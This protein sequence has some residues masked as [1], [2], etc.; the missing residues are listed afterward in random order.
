MDEFVELSEDE[1][2]ALKQLYPR[3]DTRGLK[4]LAGHLLL[5]AVATVLVYQ[6]AGSALYLPGA[7]V[8]GMVVIFL[9]APLHETIHR[10]AFRSRFLNDTVAT[11]AGFILLLPPRWFRAFHLHHHRYTQIEG[12]DPELTDKKIA[13]PGQYLTHVSGLPYWRDAVV[14]LIRHAFG[15]VSA[16]YIVERATPPVIRE[17]RAYLTAYLLIA[18]LSIGFQSAAAVTFWLIP[19]LLGQPVLRLYLLAEHT[20]CPLV[21]D[22]LRNSRTTITSAT[23]RFLAWNMP[24]HAEHHACMALP[25]HALP[26]AHALFRDRIHTLTPGYLAFNRQLVRDIRERAG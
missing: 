21:P 22:M 12:R 23:V 19:V 10:T 13:S 17:A 9:F 4:H 6:S 11:L 3:S 24:Y 5:I 1:R 8:L 2:R 15:Y 14:T 20:G 18:V 7:F 25:F 16:P 26:K